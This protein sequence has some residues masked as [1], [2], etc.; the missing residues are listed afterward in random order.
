MPPYPSVISLDFYFYHVEK[1]A[2]MSLR[3]AIYAAFKERYADEQMHIPGSTRP[4]EETI[5]DH[6]DD[7]DYF[8]RVEVIADHS[9]PG[10]LAALL[11]TSVSVR[12]GVT[13]LRHPVDRALSH[14]H[15]FYGEGGSLHDV[16]PERLERFMRRHGNLQTTRLSNEGESLEDALAALRSMDAIIIVEDYPRSV[17]LLNRV[18]PF[19]VRFEDSFVENVTGADDEASYKTLYSDDFKRSLE[20]FCTN[21]LQLYAEGRRL[22]DEMCARAGV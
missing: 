13:A 16:S 11:R 18:N 8:E 15:Y 4:G 10:E 21:D 5:R 1:C 9:N 14:F 17:E 2:G 19:G 6:A 12:F 20:R 7:A 22:F 3:R